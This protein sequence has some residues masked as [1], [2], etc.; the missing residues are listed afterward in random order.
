MSGPGTL[1]DEALLSLRDTSGHPRLSVCDTQAPQHALHY[2]GSFEPGDRPLL[3]HG[4]RQR[5]C[6]EGLDKQIKRFVPKEVCE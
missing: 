4:L 2:S 1:E 3:L 5:Y 6:Y